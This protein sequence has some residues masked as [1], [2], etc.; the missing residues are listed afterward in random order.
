M[1]DTYF[2][3]E[4][5][6]AEKIPSHCT[7]G[8]F[9]NPET[10][11]PVSARSSH[12]AAREHPCRLPIQPRVNSGSTFRR[13][14]PVG[15]LACGLPEKVGGMSLIEQAGAVEWSSQRLAWPVLLLLRSENVSE[16]L[17]WPSRP[18]QRCDHERLRATAAA[19]ANAL[20][21]TRV[22]P[23]DLSA[24]RALSAGPP[25]CNEHAA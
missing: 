9:P 16:T 23:L 25:M 3:D 21:Q 18:A 12:H 8:T 1:D 11:R 20:A 2:L 5:V 6:K 19:A 4:E 17:R 24:Y 15:A 22:Y 7:I 14:D 10:S 13:T